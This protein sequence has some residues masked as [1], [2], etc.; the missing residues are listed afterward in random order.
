MFHDDIDGFAL[1]QGVAL[2]AP[3]RADGA[4]PWH[5]KGLRGRF[6][7]AVARRWFAGVGA[8]L[9]QARLQFKDLLLLLC[10]LRQQALN[11]LVQLIIALQQLPVARRGLIWL[12]LHGLH[13]RLGLSS[14]KI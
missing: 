1:S 14:Y 9:A 11:Q 8:V 3:G 5:A 13:C 4:L 2:V 6:A 10:Q 12:F 7:Q